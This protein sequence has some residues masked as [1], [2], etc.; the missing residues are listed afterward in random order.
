MSHKICNN[1]S[2]ENK[3]LRSAVAGFLKSSEAFMLNQLNS[4]YLFSLNYEYDILNELIE[5]SIN[6]TKILTRNT[7][8]GIIRNFNSI[9][10]G[11]IVG[12]LIFVLILFVIIWFSVIAVRLKVI[13]Q[14]SKMLEAIPVQYAAKSPLIAELIMNEKKNSKKYIKDDN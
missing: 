1:D 12:F 6:K 4:E 2:L 7:L 3:G 8:D 10:I 9:K 11:F 14:L 5:P 13:Q